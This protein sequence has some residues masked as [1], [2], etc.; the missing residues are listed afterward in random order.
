VT[1]DKWAKT[2]SP[3]KDVKVYI[4]APSG[5]QAASNGYVDADTL[6]SYAI[7][8]RNQF[9]SFGGIML[10]DASWAYANDNFA[11]TVKK[12]L[13]V[14]GNSGQTNS[15]AL[16][17]GPTQHT[18]APSTQ[19]SA[20]KTSTSGSPSSSPSS[21]SCS[22]VASWAANVTYTGGCQVSYAGHIWTAKWWSIDDVPGGSSGVWED[23]GYC[24][25]AEGGKTITPVNRA[26][27]TKAAKG[28]L[29]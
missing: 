28:A 11:A 5:P 18:S 15:S 24:N 12:A 21:E 23:M 8:M 10:W 19:K 7:Q 27:Q 3:N 29:T 2:V 9:S 14:G 1:R 17:S 4:G 6:A 20:T 22:A 25:P 13:L 26:I 16:P